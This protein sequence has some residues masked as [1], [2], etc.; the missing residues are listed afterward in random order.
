MRTLI[1]T[2]AGAALAASLIAAPFPVF[3]Q[4]SGNDVKK[5]IEALKQGQQEILKQ[6]E[7]IKKLVQARP[8]AAPAGPNVKDVVFAL[9]N[10][11]IRGA[12]TAK[13]TMVEFTDYQ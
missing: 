5:E 1:R 8:A 6:L 4:G 12:A 3:A 13:L 7:E 10:N 2:G 11:P 9:G